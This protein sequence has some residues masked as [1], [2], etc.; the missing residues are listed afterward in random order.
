MT[1][2]GKNVKRLRQEIRYSQFLLAGFCEVSEAYI[3]MIEN[4]KRIPSV[5]VLTKMATALVCSVSE[6]LG[7]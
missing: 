3:S 2:V 5:E 4:G 7:E 1:E 6:I